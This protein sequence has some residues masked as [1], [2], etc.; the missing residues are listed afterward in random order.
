MIEK[1]SAKENGLILTPFGFRTSRLSEESN[2]VTIRV[3]PSL[4]ELASNS[5]KLAESWID[6]ARSL[7][8]YLSN[9]LSKHA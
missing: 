6:N 5:K 9:L 8:R 2:D 3:G 4:N 7:L 1:K